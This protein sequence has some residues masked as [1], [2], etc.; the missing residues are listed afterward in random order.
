MES[1]SV[2]RAKARDIEERVP[3]RLYSADE[4]ASHNKR[5]D[6]WV[7]IDKKV[8]LSTVH[9]SVCSVSSLDTH[10]SALLNCI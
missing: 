1:A 4:V 2:R 7:I 6:C 8:L 5:D 10:C 9:L 3:G